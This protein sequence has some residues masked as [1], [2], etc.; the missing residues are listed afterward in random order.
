[1]VEEE[2]EEAEVNAVINN[3]FNPDFSFSVA[4]MHQSG[5]EDK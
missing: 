3:V 2:V 5:V 1:M 4:E